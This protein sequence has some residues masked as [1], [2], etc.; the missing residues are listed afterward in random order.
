ML[1]HNIGAATKTYIC[2]NTYLHSDPLQ[3]KKFSNLRAMNDLP[4]PGRPTRTS[5]RR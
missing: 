1:Q 2:A 4:R 5:T 3:L